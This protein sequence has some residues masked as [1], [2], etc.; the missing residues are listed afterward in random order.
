MDR[1]LKLVDT[2][3]QVSDELHLF[4]LSACVGRSCAGRP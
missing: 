2:V 3:G 1:H 4:S